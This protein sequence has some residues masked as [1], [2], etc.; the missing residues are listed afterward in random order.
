MRLC[1]VAVPDAV[2]AMTEWMAANTW[3]PPVRPKPSSPEPETAV[4]DRDAAALRRQ[5]DLLHLAAYAACAMLADGDCSPKAGGCAAMRP[6]SRIGRAGCSDSRSLRNGTRPG[7]RVTSCRGYAMKPA[8]TSRNVPIRQDHHTSDRTAAF[9]AA[10]AA[11]ADHPTHGVSYPGFAVRVRSTVKLTG[12]KCHC[13]ST[14]LV[15]ESR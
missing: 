5:F 1:F 6:V 11:A 12:S 13:P 4:N 9:R 2:D 15:V 10:P 7:R 3:T 14:A 8:R